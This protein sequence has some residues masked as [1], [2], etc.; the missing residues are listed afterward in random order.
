MLEVRVMRQLC[1]CILCTKLTMR[2]DHAIRTH[3]A[4]QM[5]SKHTYWMLGNVSDF[6]SLS[7]SLFIRERCMMASI[8]YFKPTR[9]VMSEV[10]AADG[11]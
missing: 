1:S 11:G 8:Q 4:L 7:G 10:N 6:Q 3:F 9:L 2:S 5:C